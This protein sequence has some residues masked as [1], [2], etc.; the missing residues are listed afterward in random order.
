VQSISELTSPAGRRRPSHNRCIRTTC[1]DAR[2]SVA[3]AAA[4]GGGG[5]DVCDVSRVTP[6]TT[7]RICDRSMNPSTEC[8]HGRQTNHTDDLPTTKKL[9]ADGTR[10]SAKRHHNASFTI[11][12]T[13]AIICSSIRTYTRTSRN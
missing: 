1:Q 8:Q 12:A 10:Y 2:Q 13:C 5:S 9:H 3:A 7:R 4:A 6:P 11:I